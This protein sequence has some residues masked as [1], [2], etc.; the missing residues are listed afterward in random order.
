MEIARSSTK[1]D[2]K[3]T[4]EQKK[5]NKLKKKKEKLTKSGVSKRDSYIETG[6]NPYD[7]TS[8]SP[9]DQI[10]SMTNL[11]NS[12]G[13]WD[14]REVQFQKNKKLLKAKII[15]I[16]DKDHYGENENDDENNINGRNRIEAFNFDYDDNNEEL[17]NSEHSGTKSSR[18]SKD[19]DDQGSVYSGVASKRGLT[20]AMEDFFDSKK[21]EVYVK[22][23]VK[24]N[25][26]Y[27]VIEEEEEEKEE[28][29][30][31][32]GKDEEE[33]IQE[34]KESADI[35]NK[36]MSIKKLLKLHKKNT[37][38]SNSSNLIL[39]ENEGDDLSIDGRKSTPQK[40]FS[41]GGQPV[42]NF[43]LLV[44]KGKKMGDDESMIS[45]KN[46]IKKHDIKKTIKNEELKEHLFQKRKGTLTSM[47]DINKTSNLTNN[48]ISSTIL[49]KKESSKT[50][51]I[52]LKSVH[53]QPNNLNK[54][55]IVSQE[56]LNNNDS[57]PFT[58]PSPP[59]FNENP[60]VVTNNQQSIGANS[61]H[62]AIEENK[63][64]VPELEENEQNN[65]IMNNII[66]SEDRQEG[67]VSF[68]LIKKFVKISGGYWIFIL[69]LFFMSLNSSLK[70][71]QA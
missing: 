4:K 19:K 27:E 62:T 11:G 37:I 1:P 54:D 21:T 13:F 55:S 18:I 42:S 58:S 12:Q 7:I 51:V 46:L 44:K 2:K 3:K 63:V 39:E 31:E 15:H 64:P 23:P 50:S 47:N 60:N 56:N 24:P 48:N 10:S 38:V 9:K 41:S 65:E 16:N 66:L 14:P 45:G 25:E 33:I 29:G 69:I 34:R 67:T 43:P 57:S 71:F 68:N 20:Q 6:N 70:M 40:E 36:N 8:N 53:V 5:L 30:K 52:S 35:F 22:S 49:I 28:E 59:T 26:T 61:T 32:V 17:N